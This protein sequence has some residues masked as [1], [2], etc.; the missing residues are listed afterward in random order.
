MGPG[1]IL[2]P[3]HARSAL[4]APSN[5]VP[6]RSIG[7]EVEV[8]DIR[9]A[10]D[11]YQNDWVRLGHEALHANPAFEL[12]ILGAAAK[13]FA[14]GKDHPQA[15]LIW[16]VAHS[17]HCPNVLIGAF[18]CALSHLRW[19]VPVPVAALWRH[20]FAFAGQPLVHAMHA[21][22]ALSAFFHWLDEHHNGRA[23]CL[24]EKIPAEGPFHDALQDYLAHSDRPAAHFGRHERAA[25]R[26]E[27]D[28][29]DYFATA[30]SNKK[31][32]EFRRLKKR[33]G[34]QGKLSFD[35]F[36][37]TDGVQSWCDAFLTLEAGGW[38]GRTGTALA[39]VDGLASVVRQGFAAEAQTGNLLFWRL[40]L[41][42]VPVAMACGIRRGAQA[43]L[44]KIAH[45]ESFAR[46]SPGVLLILELTNGLVESDTIDWVDSC[47]DADHPMI[48]HLWRERMPVTD[49]L[50]AGPRMRVPFKMLCELEALRRNTRSKAAQLYHRLKK[51]LAT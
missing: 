31:R 35:R 51:G 36:D 24:F 42:G 43:W 1:V 25:L 13:A 3:T 39:Q 21:G 38:K 34:E 17:G 28:N 20:K 18:V 2:S 37:K 50:V 45:D 15:V 32:K 4:T 46:F 14:T 48:D 5:A 7:A 11:L 27:A 44:L 16:D 12:D 40:T 23:A 10:L 9:T 19:G 47:A 22:R 41:D 33:L 29:D 49:V 30:L 8:L 26:A 6:A